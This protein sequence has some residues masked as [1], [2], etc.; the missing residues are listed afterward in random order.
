MGGEWSAEV[1]EHGSWH[2]KQDFWS[3]ISIR[4]SDWFFFLVQAIRGRWSIRCFSLDVMFLV[5]RDQVVFPIAYDE[6]CVIE[7]EFLR[8]INDSDTPTLEMFACLTVN[9]MLAM[10]KRMHTKI[11][12]GKANGRDSLTEYIRDHWNTFRQRLL[13]NGIQTEHHVGKQ[14]IVF[15]KKSE[16]EYF[17]LTISS[18]FHCGF[19]EWPWEFAE[20]AI[21]REH[22]EDNECCWHGAC[23]WM[24]AGRWF[25]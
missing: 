25:S 14:D 9:Q 3:K 24:V 15:L 2:S 20:S 4:A 16:R 6:G 22:G 5:K 11:T 18:R 21:H 13:E 17:P 1:V 12:N 23:H 10:M 19:P 8:G 7:L